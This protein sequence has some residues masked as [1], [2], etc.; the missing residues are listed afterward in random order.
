MGYE[1]LFESGVKILSSQ[2]ESMK[3]NV[4]HTA[5]IGEDGDGNDAFAA[6]VVRRA[7][8]DLS[9][10]ARVTKAG[11]TVMTFATLQFLEPIAN[12][13]PN[14]GKIREQP[15]DPRDSLVLPDGGTAPI[16]S[17][18][19]FADSVTTQPFVVEVVLGTVMIGVRGD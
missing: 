14:A 2:F 10:Q 1:S 5:W 16:V 17:T 11:R 12:T 7:L 4:T 6:P 3:L 15:I 19:G 13:T 9:K 18:G 8:V